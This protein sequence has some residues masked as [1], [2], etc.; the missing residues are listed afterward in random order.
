MQVNKRRHNQRRKLFPRAHYE[1]LVRG[2][3]RQSILRL[4]KNRTYSHAD[5]KNVCAWQFDLLSKFL[6]MIFAAFLGLKVFFLF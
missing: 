4:T 3:F 5:C 6:I 1:L 2:E